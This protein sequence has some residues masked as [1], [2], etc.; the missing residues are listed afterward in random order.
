MSTRLPSIRKA[1]TVRNLWRLGLGKA[2]RITVD[3]PPIRP[4]I[5]MV[6]APA[7]PLTTPLLRSAFAFPVHVVGGDIAWEPP[8][9]RATAQAIAAINEG[10]AV[11]VVNTSPAA[12]AIALATGVPLVAV[13]ISG[14][15][16]RIPTD[17]ARPGS[18]IDIQVSAPAPGLDRQDH[19]TAAHIRLAQEMLRQ[20]ILDAWKAAA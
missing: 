19:P 17:P 7:G 3:A 8:G 11:A 4:P 12:A 13:Q 6:C 16:A 2:Y 5:L 9:I 14:A 15:H 10:R 18:H 20:R 1:A